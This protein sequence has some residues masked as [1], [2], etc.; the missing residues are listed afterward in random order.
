MINRRE[1]MEHIFGHVTEAA[2]LIV[3][4][5]DDWE[6]MSNEDKE[7]TMHEIKRKVDTVLTMLKGRHLF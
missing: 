3:G 4:L 6:S 1:W 5:L 2:A 7:E